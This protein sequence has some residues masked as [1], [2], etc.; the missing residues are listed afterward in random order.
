MPDRLAKPNIVAKLGIVEPRPQRPA[1]ML[2]NRLEGR[3]RAHDFSRSLKAEVRDPLW[4]ISRQWQ[5]GE[6]LGDDAASPILAKALLRTSKLNKYQAGIEPA[7][8][9]D[10]DVPLEA[11]VERQAIPFKQAKMP[12]SLDLRLLMGRQWLKLI[13]PAHAAL[14]V[15]YIKLY[16]FDRPD[17]DRESDA[18]ICAHQDAWQQFAAVSG[19]CMDGYAL[20]DYLNTDATPR[21]RASDNIAAIT[22][23]GERDALDVLAE[24]FQ[25]WFRDLF[26]QPL[27]HPNASWRPPYL[28]HQF[29][30]SSPIGGLE[31][32]L[33][34]DE[35]HH[36][37]LDWYNLDIAREQDALVMAPEAP[38]P[39]GTEAAITRTFVPT[40]VSF[41]GMPH[42]RWWRFENWRTDISFI[43]PDTTDLNKLLLVDFILVYA[44]DWFMVPVTLDA[45]TIASVNGLMVT[46]VFG[47]STWVT[48]S[49]SG[50]DEDW[51]RWAM[52]TH[53]TRGTDDVAAD[54][55]LSL[56]PV[57]RK[58]LEG[59]PLEEVY[60]LRDEV[61]NMV[62]A[63]ESQVP[64]ASGRSKAGKQ[65]GEELHL[66][67]QQLLEKANPAPIE[68]P[69][70]AAVRYRIVNSV[71]EHWIP[72]VPVHV[73]GSNREVQLQRAAMPRFLTGD[74]RKPRKIE[75]RTSLMREGLESVQKLP[76]F[77]H[78]EE[79]S[80]AG[81]VVRKGFQRTRWYDGRVCTWLGIRKQVGK[82]S[83][84]SG[85]VFDQLVPAEPTA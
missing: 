82:G 14:K 22:T 78:E 65:A 73:P 11:R 55:S 47:D 52:F 42:P 68:L 36:G 30:C 43:K 32:V 13:G 70:N 39:F 49:G 54:L 85:L 84:S 28:E 4:L 66:K 6:F 50:P 33:V 63:V 80:R 76:Y 45:G 64:L 71:P 20:Y 10:E 34:A 48:A 5:M 74:N 56:L 77:L 69:A 60:L 29:G 59:K 38:A 83:G 51:Q 16:G 25:R 12:M 31:R 27:D 57:A 58:V 61:A 23:D 35:Y 79:V 24:Q 8:S 81:I 40:N 3:A 62:W 67:L 72:L 75:P 2:Y 15:D 7:Q 17:P 1:V 18:R 46:D 19:R 21:P 44:N 9:L 37:H 53:S 26:Y 41:G